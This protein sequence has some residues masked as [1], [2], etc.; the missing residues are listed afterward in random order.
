[1]SRLHSKL[2]QDLWVESQ[3]HYFQQVSNDSYEA[4]TA[5]IFSEPL[6][7]QWLN[8]SY[9]WM[10][11]LCFFPSILLIFIFYVFCNETYYNDVINNNFFKRLG[12]R[13]AAWYKIL[14]QESDL[15]LKSCLLLCHTVFEP[16]LSSI[17]QGCLYTFV[18]DMTIIIPAF[19]C[20]V[21][22]Q[23]IFFCPFT[24]FFLYF[25]DQIYLL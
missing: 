17:N 8:S 1:M 19:F 6:D 10:V 9:L 22:V 3:N 20:L 13:G 4:S 2:N 18:S 16:N 23:Y 11:G 15:S 12:S 7:H 14:V 25:Y 5:L 24:L 21:F